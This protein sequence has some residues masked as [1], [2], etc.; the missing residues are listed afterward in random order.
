MTCLPLDVFISFWLS[1]F[2]SFSNYLTIVK[3]TFKW[4]Y[5]PLY[6]FAHHTGVVEEMVKEDREEEGRRALQGY[7]KGV[8]VGF[9]RIFEEE[10]V[11][12]EGNGWRHWKE[13]QR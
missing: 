10:G 3:K 8:F 2:Y 12:V 6:S 11:A 4:C 7:C 1:L 13:D 5:E 9:Y